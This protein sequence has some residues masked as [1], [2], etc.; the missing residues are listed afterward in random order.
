MNCPV[1]RAL[2]RLVNEVD[3][4]L[5]LRCPERALPLIE[6][7]LAEPAARA[8]GL[9]LRVRAL[10]RMGAF[11]DALA[12]LAALRKVHEDDDWMDLTEAWCRRRDTAPLGPRPNGMVVGLSG[13]ASGPSPN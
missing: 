2:E 12:D 6:P 8:C 5:E 9:V 3:G 4:W 7:L 10:A 1:P 11:A 13:P